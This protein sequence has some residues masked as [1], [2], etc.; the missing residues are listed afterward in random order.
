[1]KYYIP[2][3]TGSIQNF[4]APQNGTYK[5]EVWGAQGGCATGQPV[6][7][8]KL[9]K[10]GYS[11]GTTKLGISN[12]V[13]I[14]VGASG[15]STSGGY[16]G[17]YPAYQYGG[18]G[19]GASHI[20]TTNRGILANYVNYQS[21]VIIV[22]GGGGGVDFSGTG[23]YG[24][25]II[26][27]AGY[28]ASTI[29]STGGTQTSPGSGAFWGYFGVGGL[30][31]TDSGNPANGCDC[32]AAGGGGWYGGGGNTIYNQGGG[33]GG[34][35]HIGAGVTGTTIA[36]DQSFPSPNGGTEIG[37]SGNGYCVISW[38]P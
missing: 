7:D 31:V 2:P 6:D 27:G 19:G 32:S 36:G 15:K 29:C 16:N 28:L 30:G 21:E 10:G 9:G 1:M 11:Y 18:A 37:H 38:I 12:I 25:G 24:G 20:A 23:G 13:Y 17:G 8:S 4:T 14:C 33:G 35:G 34:S 3:N 22:A 26:G 5:L